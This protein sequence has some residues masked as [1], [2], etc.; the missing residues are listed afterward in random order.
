MV[1]WKYYSVTAFRKVMAAYNKCIKS[2][3]VMQDVT[4]YQ[5]Y[6]YSSVFQLLTLLCV[7]LV[8]CLQVIAY[9]HAIRLLSGLQ[10]FLC[11][12]FILCVFSFS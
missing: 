4:V 8:F 10:T 3:L 1:L 12:N 9:C 7:I 2:C 11:G 5:A 6:F